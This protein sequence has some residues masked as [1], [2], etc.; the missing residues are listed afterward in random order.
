MKIWKVILAA[1]VIFAAGIMTGAVANRSYHRS[2]RFFPRE[3]HE[4]VANVAPPAANS[5]REAHLSLP[6]MKPPGRG[7]GKEFLEHLEKEL[8]LDEEQHK[9]VEKILSESQKRTKELWEKVAPEMREEMK[10]SREAIREILTPEQ[11]ARMDELLKHAPKPPKEGRATNS[12]PPAAEQSSNPP[13]AEV[14]AK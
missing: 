2:H 7:Q 14:P 9:R 5:N 13:P 1:L 8:K 6:F 3:Q 11:N 10:R 12:T 4:P